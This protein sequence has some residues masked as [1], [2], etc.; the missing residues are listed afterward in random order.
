MKPFNCAY[1]VSDPKNRACFRSVFIVAALVCGAYFISNA[2][3]T[4]EYKDRLSRWEVINMLR[5]SK[6][7]TCKNQCRPPG[8]EALPQGIVVKTSNLQMQPLWRDSVK[9]VN[10]A[11][12]SN[13][14]AIA[15]GI[16]Q[17]EIVDQIVKKFP[18][19][20]FVVMLFHYDGI[21]DEWKDFEWSDRAIHVSAVNQTKWWFAKRFLHP[22]IVSKYKYI[23]LWDE[24]L[25]VD[26]F[27]PKQYL[28]IVE[29]EGLEI[30]QPALD[31]VKSEVHHP[32]TARRKNSKFHR[33]M[34]KFKGHGRC[35]SQSTAP[36]CIGWVEMMAPVFSRAAWR[37]VWYM[38]QNDL[39]HAWGLDMQL[40]YCAQGDRMKNVGVVDAQ[41][42]VHFGLPTLGVTEENEL[43]STEVKITQREQLPKSESP[44]PSESHK[45]DNRPEVRRQ[46]FIEMQT[47]RKRWENA[48]KDDECWVDPYQQMS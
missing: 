29:G 10:P 3:I 26:N 31:P 44:A 42:I 35:D 46:S 32:I 7:N 25:G 19:S 24:D 8:S 37:C 34:Y 36:P 12:S 30:S 5:N 17:K 43:N 22:D 6:S 45:I 47:F 18:I 4:N 28:S 1:V 16:K 15:V 38:I 2:F 23:F 20:D 48:A 14:L 11:T 33:R 9:N 40:G 21:V 13:L 27:D 39:I 41:Y